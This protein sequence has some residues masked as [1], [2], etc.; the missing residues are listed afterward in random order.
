M[1]VS[2]ID[3]VKYLRD[4]IRQEDNWARQAETMEARHRHAELALHY[5]MKLQSLSARGVAAVQAQTPA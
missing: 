1:T 3:E 2:P 4:R 5:R